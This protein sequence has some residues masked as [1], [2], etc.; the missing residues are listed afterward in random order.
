MDKSKIQQYLKDL[1]NAG[2][3]SPKYEEI[4]DQQRITVKQHY[5]RLGKF[6]WLVDFC[7]L[8]GLTFD[9]SGA[10][11]NLGNPSLF[12]TIEDVKE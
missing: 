1:V 6:G 2:F 10:K 5:I 9:I 3:D 11:D 12:L 4:I 8:N 7:N